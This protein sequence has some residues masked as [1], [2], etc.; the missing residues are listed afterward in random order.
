M[1]FWAFQI[2]QMQKKWVWKKQKLTSRLPLV[3]YRHWSFP[4]MH[5][6]L[7][8]VK[9]LF[10]KSVPSVSLWKNNVYWERMLDLLAGNNGF[11]LKY[12]KL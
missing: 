7:H 5:L 9:M 8:F 10:R 11:W 2:P 12:F 3:K 6:H 1:Q 4:F